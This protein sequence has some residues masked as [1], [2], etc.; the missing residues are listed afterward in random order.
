[1]DKTPESRLG[2]K[3]GLTEFS[4]AEL[5]VLVVLTGD[6]G[7]E[8]KSKPGGGN[9][10]DFSACFTRAIR[11][12]SFVVKRRRKNFREKRFFCLFVKG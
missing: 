4:E 3:I 6:S 10:V 7:D 2:D 11:D 8:L 9:F 5:M 1:M 12:S